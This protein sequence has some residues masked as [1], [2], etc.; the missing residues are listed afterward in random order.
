MSS[1]RDWKGTAMKPVILL[2]A[3]AATIGAAPSRPS[4]P[5]APA[6]RYEAG[7]F[8]PS[9][10]FVIEHGR[11][12]FDPRTGDPVISVPLPRR[13][14]I[15]NGYRYV[16][17][18][19]SVTVRHVRCDSYDGRTFEDTVHPSWAAE[20]GCGGTAIPPS[21]L[22]DSGWQIESAAGLRSREQD[23]YSVG[24]DGD[25][26][27]TIQF[28][29]HEYRGTYIERRP[30]LTVGRL[31][32]TDHFCWTSAMETRLLAILRTPVRMS[33]VDG[34]TLVLTGPGGS[35]RLLPS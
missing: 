11:M 23:T 8:E 13:Q 9:W 33:W 1:E 12:T 16:T 3:A 4:S 26:R 2:F 29:C 32:G 31:A 27:I 35:I 17:R 22:A 28:R 21:T 30:V 20:A 6:P 25:G 34:D 7:G 24:F 10:L 18:D 15:R 14:P 5:A 19:L